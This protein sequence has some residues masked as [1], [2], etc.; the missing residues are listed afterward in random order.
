MRLRRRRGISVEQ[1]GQSDIPVSGAD[2]LPT[3][4]SPR[5]ATALQRVPSFETVLGRYGVGLIVII[6]AK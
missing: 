5:Q 3:I 4:G 2:P 6:Y 1:R